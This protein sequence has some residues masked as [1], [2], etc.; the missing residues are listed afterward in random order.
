MDFWKNMIGKNILIVP[1]W[2]ALSENSDN[3]HL[4]IMAIKHILKCQF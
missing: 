2:F 1:F 4:K 3:Y